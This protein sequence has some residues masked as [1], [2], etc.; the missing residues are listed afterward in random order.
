MRVTLAG[1]PWA[2][3]A[4]F[5][6]GAKVPVTAKALAALGVAVI[7]PFTPTGIKIQSVAV[8]GVRLPTS[9]P[10]V[11]LGAPCAAERVRRRLQASRMRRRFMPECASKD[12]R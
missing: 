11:P 4:R 1:V 8:E 9:G 6:T 10:V 2:F 5:S 7:S 3:P 12:Q